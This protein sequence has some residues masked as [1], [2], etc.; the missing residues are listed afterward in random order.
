MYLEILN[1]FDEN[2]FSQNY[3]MYLYCY[4]EIAQTTIN[5]TYSRFFFQTFND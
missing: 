3:G 1:S 2:I 4:I 5:Y